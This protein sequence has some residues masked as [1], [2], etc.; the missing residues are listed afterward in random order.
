MRTF[1]R[2]TIGLGLLLGS[3]ICA[4]ASVA[5]TNDVDFQHPSSGAMDQFTGSSASD[6][7][8]NSVESFS[9]DVASQ[10][11]GSD[12]TEQPAVIA[13]LPA[14]YGIG[15]AGGSKNTGSDLAASSSQFGKLPSTS[16]H[17]DAVTN[18]VATPEPSSLPFLGASAILIGMLV[19]RKLLKAN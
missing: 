3:G 13:Y 14:S 16:D 18:F 7:A 6:K 8:V 17:T 15:N 2:V 12:F 1:S 11:K 19:R 10:D 9:I 5:L 4:M